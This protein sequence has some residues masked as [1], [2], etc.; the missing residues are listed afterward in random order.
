MKNRHRISEAKFFKV[1]EGIKNMET[2]SPF[3]EIIEEIR[4]LGGEAVR[5]CYQCGKCDTVCPWNKVTDFSIRKLIREAVFG[6]PEVELEDVWRCTTCGK[7]PQKCPRDVKQINDVVAMRRM[8]T[9]YG[10]SNALLKPVRSASASLA[11]EGNPFVQERAKRAEWA[12]GQNVKPFTEDMEILYFACCYV[13]YDTRLREIANATAKILNTAGVSFGI[14]GTQENCC[15]ESIR[16]TGNE[17]L[18]KRLAKDN[19]KTFIENGVKRILVSSPHCLHTFKNEFPEFSAHF[20]VVHITEYVQELL[21]AG[22]LQIKGEY[23]KKITYHDPCYLGRHN[24]VFDPPREILKSIPGLEFKE[25]PEAREESLCCGMG[26]GRVWIDTKMAERFAN[27]RIEQAIGVEA[28]VLVTAC[29]YC[30]IALEDS[31][32]GLGYE[33]K[34]QVKDITEILQEVI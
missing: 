31:R 5:F 10:V 23:N 34:I 25:L 22:R 18:F 14:L 6:L 28:E 16:K 29:P 26:G 11:A 13:S 3:K 24:G 7:C 17:D 27:L 15:G 12:A 32:L 2:E 30:I 1:K 20:E 33:D 21:N 19:I 8:A 9:G 4:E